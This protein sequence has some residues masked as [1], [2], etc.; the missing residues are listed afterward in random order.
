MNLDRVLTGFDEGF[1]FEVLLE[2]LEKAFD[3]PTEF[4]EITDGR[5]IEIKVICQQNQLA[6]NRLIANRSGYF[7]RKPR[8]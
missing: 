3:S 6:G 7:S 5:E 1:D 4:I 2:H 8:K